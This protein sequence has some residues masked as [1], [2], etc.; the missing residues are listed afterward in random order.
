MASSYK[1]TAND[2]SVVFKKSEDNTLLDC[3]LKN[4]IK[5]NY[6]CKEGFCGACRAELKSGTFE[7]TN[8]PLACV[9]NG[10]VLTC[11]CKPT[12]DLIIKVRL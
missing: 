1:I 10:E 5:A 2:K 7:Y 9:R 3:L 12:S 4:D 11:C 6:H 8:E